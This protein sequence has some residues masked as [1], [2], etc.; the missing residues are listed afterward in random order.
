M[1]NLIL[2]W[3]TFTNSFRA[4]ML[5]VASLF[6]I[7][8]AILVIVSKNPVLLWDKLSNSGNLLKLLIPSHSCKRIGGWINN[9]CMVI[10]QLIIERLMDYRGSKSAKDKSIISLLVFVLFAYI[11]LILPLPELFFYEL[12][13]SSSNFGRLVVFP[14]QKNTFNNI[15]YTPSSTSFF[16]PT[17]FF[18]IIIINLYI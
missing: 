10:T 18:F 16:F 8:C 13:L 3:E 5:D 9:S 15:K 6:A 4:E 17:K 2:L 1:I 14:L 11:I 12:L 7:F